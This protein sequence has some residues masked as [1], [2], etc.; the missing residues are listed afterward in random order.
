[1]PSV[2]NGKL[3][4]REDNMKVSEHVVSNQKIAAE[5]YFETEM[6]DFAFSGFL[7]CNNGS[8][9]EQI[10]VAGKLTMR[11]DMV[12]VGGTDDDY[13]SVT[14]KTCTPE[15]FERAPD[16]IQLEEYV[17]KE[18]TDLLRLSFGLTGMMSSRALTRYV[19]Q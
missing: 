15:Y 2:Q 11:D 8:C 10:A 18:V 16:I 12:P 17:P 19:S 9:K 13:E 14:F 5:D 6:L 4:S 7:V 3:V 1:M